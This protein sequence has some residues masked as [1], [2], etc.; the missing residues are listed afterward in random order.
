MIRVY[1]CPSCGSELIYDGGTDSLKCPHCGTTV[2]V[3]ELEAKTDAGETTGLTGQETADNAGNGIREFK[4]PSCG[5]NLVTDEHTAATFCSFCGS[6]TLIEGRLSG[7]FKPNRVIPFAFDKKQAQQNFRSWTGTGRLTPSSFKSQ[8]VMDKVTG[9]YVPY[10][11]YSY[12]MEADITAEAENVRAEIIGDTEYIH[13]DH[14]LL[15]R[16]TNGEYRNVPHDAS[17]KMPDESMDI[18]APYDFSKMVDFA[19][20]YLSGFMAEK[21]NADA[22]AYE[23]DVKSELQSDFAAI[24]HDMLDGYEAI[25]VTNTD[26]RFNNPKIEYVMLPVW[27]L[28]YEYGGKKYPLYMNGQTGKIDGELPISKAKTAA[29]FAGAFVVCFLIAFLLGGVL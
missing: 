14:F 28:N 12:D 10:W 6:P 9:V 13:T 16:T 15:D 17:E 8:A 23:G 7:E 20:P 19:M 29:L 11:L 1:K 3:S 2:T 27:T 5:A 21:Y 24:S 22:E 4:C 26:V 18:L 25:N